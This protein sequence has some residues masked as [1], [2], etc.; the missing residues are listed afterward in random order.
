MNW[1]RRGKRLFPHRVSE[2]PASAAGSLSAL[3]M[4]RLL[5]LRAGAVIGWVLAL[6]FVGWQLGISLPFVTMSA[7]IAVWCIVSLVS[8]VR[9][10]DREDIEDRTFVL[11]LLVDVVMLGL[12]LYLSGGS[13]NPLT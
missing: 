12:L 13:T 6:L 10:R 2:R 1:L 7:L 4:Q 3:N 5:L 11:Q 9:L 8:W